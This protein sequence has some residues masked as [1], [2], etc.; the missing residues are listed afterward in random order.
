MPERLASVGSAN[1]RRMSPS[2]SGDQ[3]ENLVY[4]CTYPRRLGDEVSLSHLCRR[5]ARRRGVA[6]SAALG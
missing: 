5:A 6:L 3:S 2:S 4:Q 1:R